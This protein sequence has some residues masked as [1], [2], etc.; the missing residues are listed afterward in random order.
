QHQKVLF[1]VAD[2]AYDSQRIYEIAR[3]CNIFAINPINPRN[4]E[5]NKSTHC[6]I[7]SQFIQTILGKQLMKERGK[8]KQQFS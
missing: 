6:R 3:A 4:G 7:L 1:S 8:I 5:Q 2:A